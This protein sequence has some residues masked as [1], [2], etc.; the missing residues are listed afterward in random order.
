M[1]APETSVLRSEWNAALDNR[2]LD[3]L[4][5]LVG[6]RAQIVTGEHAGKSGTIDSFGL[7]QGKPYWIA[8]DE[9]GRIAVADNEVELP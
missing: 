4:R 5:F 8:T 9:G 7:R 3:K 1:D 6:T 2:T